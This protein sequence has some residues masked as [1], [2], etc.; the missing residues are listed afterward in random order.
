M[1]FKTQ[2]LILI[3][4]LTILSGCSNLNEMKKLYFYN[5]FTPTINA[6]T[7]LASDLL[8]CLKKR[9]ISRALFF[10]ELSGKNNH[11]KIKSF[12]SPGP[13]K[14]NCEKK[15]T[16]SIPYANPYT[17]WYDES[18]KKITNDI[19]HCKS[20]DFNSLYENTIYEIRLD[21]ISNKKIHVK[22]S[23][24]DLDSLAETRYFEGYDFELM[25][26]SQNKLEPKV[27]SCMGRC[28]QDNLF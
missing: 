4:S 15:L 9:E 11:F 10:V 7:V 23:R 5:Q 19:S 28:D 20:V 6:A 24:K 25:A 2:L 16:A 17:R 26:N 27:H 18:K 12:E 22:I 3:I 13:T 14:I 1:G 21:F 8:P